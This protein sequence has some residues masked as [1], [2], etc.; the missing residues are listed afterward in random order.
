MEPRNEA[1]RRTAETC[2]FVRGELLRGWLRIGAERRDVFVYTR[3]AQRKAEDV[4][5]ESITR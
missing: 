5:L 4:E 1:S 3:I 2:G